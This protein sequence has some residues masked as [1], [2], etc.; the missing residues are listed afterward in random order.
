LE[1]RDGQGIG[2]AP[3]GAGVRRSPALWESPQPGDLVWPGAAALA[4][5]PLRG[6]GRYRPEAIGAF[7]PAK[8]SNYLR[9]DGYA[10]T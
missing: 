4:D 8:C 3:T 6:A 10:S 2:A 7:T 5:P 1:A 9:Y